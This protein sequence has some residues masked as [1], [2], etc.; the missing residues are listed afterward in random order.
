MNPNDILDQMSFNPIARAAPRQNGIYD[1]MNMKGGVNSQNLVDD[2][3]SSMEK[4]K[5]TAAEYLTLIR[6]V[7]RVPFTPSADVSAARMRDVIQVPDALSDVTDQL[8]ASIPRK[9]VE[10]EQAAVVNILSRVKCSDPRSFSWGNFIRIPVVSSALSMITKDIMNNRLP[11][12]R[13][14]MM[15]KAIFNNGQFTTMQ[16][17][18]LIRFALF[19]KCV[20]F[21]A[22]NGSMEWVEPMTQRWKVGD[23]TATNISGYWKLTA[24]PKP[25]ERTEG[26]IKDVQTVEVTIDNVAEVMGYAAVLD[27][28]YLL[29][30]SDVRQNRPSKEATMKPAVAK[31]MLGYINVWNEAKAQEYAGTKVSLG[32]KNSAFVRD[33]YEALS[34]FRATKRNFDRVTYGKSGG[35]ITHDDQTTEAPV[36]DIG[37]FGFS[38][39]PL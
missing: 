28:K 32:N 21:L 12:S 13:D 23:R 31:I 10:T 38:F 26:S 33:Y 11:R 6:A 24:R 17:I 14:I 36:D 18:L 35:P 34:S 29:M 7:K 25:A 22:S 19:I 30:C 27:A 9:R 2:L 39:Q 20:S 16:S 5:V 3:A 15:G 37:F 4:A 8:A 1:L